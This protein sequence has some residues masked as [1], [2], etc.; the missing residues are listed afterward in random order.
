MGR[1]G[2]ITMSNVRSLLVV[3]QSRKTRSYFHI[4]TLSF[5]GSHYEFAFTANGEGKLNDALDNGY[6]IHPAFPDPNKVYKSEKFFAAFD[7][8]LPSPKRSDFEHILID[9]GIER[10]YTKMD[11]LEE[12]RG[13]LAN[14]TYSFERPLRIEEDGILHTSFFIHGMRYQELP[15]DWYN[16]ID[17]NS[18]VYLGQ[19]PENEYDS[20]AVALYTQDGLQLG[21][22]P[23]FYSKALFSLMENGADPI[24]KVSYLKEKSTP[25]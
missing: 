3:W 9:L 13:R 17:V 21:Y 7:R 24:I 18:R 22:V 2:G 12:T 11:L 6:M 25:H 1:K 5:F 14:D 8:R 16:L 23:A 20:H 4:G 15:S 19:E 10:P